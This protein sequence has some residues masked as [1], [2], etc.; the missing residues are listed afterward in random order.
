[1]TLD[2]DPPP[3]LQQN[4]SPAII[5]YSI[6]RKT[7]LIYRDFGEIGVCV[8]DLTSPPPHLHITLKED[9]NRCKENIFAHSFITE[10]VIF[11][12]QRGLP[13]QRTS[14]FFL[15][16][17]QGSIRCPFIHFFLA[18]SDEQKGQ[19]W[20]FEVLKKCN[21]HK[22]LLI[23]TI[24][25]STGAR[26]IL[27]STSIFLFQNKGI[28]IIFDIIAC[29]IFYVVLLLLLLQLGLLPPSLHSRA[30]ARAF[31]SF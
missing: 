11:S 9:K 6:R 21:F 7:I 16:T 29:G 15:S 30:L 1:M 22:F 28:Y 10:L 4:H 20:S 31:I 3:S 19:R 14:M 25:Q 23:F 17:A 18:R 8:D 27:C 5:L 13:L 12:E 26:F 24:F 2:L